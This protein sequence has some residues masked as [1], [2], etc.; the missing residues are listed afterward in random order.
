L[1][2]SKAFSITRVD[3][4]QNNDTQESVTQ[5]NMIVEFL[6]FFIL[7]M[8][9]YCALNLRC[10]ISCFQTSHLEASPKLSRNC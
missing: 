6:A 2:V 5:P 10:S 9:E 7:F 4:A 3:S 8:L 1:N